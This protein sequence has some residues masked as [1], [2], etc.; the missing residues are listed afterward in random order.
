M[1]FE[2]LEIIEQNKLDYTNSFRALIAVI[3]AEGHPYEADLLQQINSEL[4]PEQLA[5]WEQWQQRYLTHINKITLITSESA[6][7]STT[8]STTQL[9]TALVIEKLQQANPVYVLRNAMAQR[10]IE[11]AEAGDF[12]EVDRLFQLLTQPYQP[13]QIATAEDITPPKR[14]AK[15]IVISCSS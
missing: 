7:K 5:I 1:A 14:D 4:N 12:S 15:P 13:Q 10:A 6:P 2:L 8:Q 11:R 9:N 3:D